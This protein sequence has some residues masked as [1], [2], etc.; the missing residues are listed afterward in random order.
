MTFNK[1]NRRL[2]VA[3]IVFISS[4][5]IVNSQTLFPRDNEHA[6]PVTAPAA[7][8]LY[9]P[10]EILNGP[11]PR[12]FF[13]E[14]PVAVIQKRIANPAYANTWK[15]I[16]EKA[17][18][19]AAAIPTDTIDVNDESLRKEAD[20]F[21]WMALAYTLDTNKKNRSIYMKGL[22]KWINAWYGYKLSTQDLVS[23][24][25]I[26]GMS[27]AYD[28]MYADFKAPVRD[29]LR[30]LIVNY[31][32]WLRS[33]KNFG[34]SMW[35]NKHYGANHNWYNNA[36]L[37][38]A[39]FALWGEKG[40]NDAD[41]PALWLNSAMRYFWEFQRRLSSEAVPIE[42]FNYADYGIKP[43]LDFAVVAEQLTNLSKLMP[44]IDCGA[45]KNSPEARLSVMLP[46]EL[47]FL[48]WSDSNWKHF[49]DSWQFR[50]CA[51][52]FNDGYAQNL[53]SIMEK[54]SNIYNWRNIFYYDP[55]IPEKAIESLPLTADFEDL[56]MY[57]ARNSWKG[58]Q[59]LF[60]FKCGLA[61]G[62]EG[63]AIERDFCTGHCQP[64][65]NT[66]TF[67]WNEHPIIDRPGYERIKKASHH[68]L[69]R[70]VYK[71]NEVEQAGGG[72]QWFMLFP[73][74]CLSG[75]QDRMGDASTLEVKHTADYHAYLGESGGLYVLNYNPC[76]YRRRVV[77]FPTGAV[78]IADRITTP[79]NTD[80]T[81]RL[82]TLRNDLK[83]EGN[84]F[85]F[86]A[87]ETKGTI[88]DYSEG[89][90]SREI[91]HEKVYAW[92][93]SD[94]DGFPIDRQVVNVTKKNTRE[95]YF[96]SVINMADNKIKIK[97]ITEQGIVVI[98]N[99]GDEIFFGWG[100]N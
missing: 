93:H 44:L 33:P 81:F 12:L 82:L 80:I 2:A 7:Q 57:V 87:G 94:T 66:V 72:R 36:A 28:W 84:V 60:N 9:T 4:C 95:A 18:S 77:Y 16:K 53:A 13:G 50:F 83:Q 54:K 89:V 3:G 55:S 64:D 42:G 30:F 23:S 20:Y 19:S 71:G 14:T 25:L 17:L 56:E 78:V 10:K 70:I 69:S 98:G 100:E 24:Q 45:I 62:K 35:R 74:D 34:A 27:N 75:Y 76:G 38:I 32:R 46:N 43:Y 88:T 51:S 65:A 15:M 49:A 31:S 52:R 99:N 58:N 61:G 67:W 22:E 8:L 1:T 6:G 92:D 21:T 39:A 79:E 48:C 86:T 68:Q 59:N 37:G 47:G 85:S 96:G 91:T 63:A 73:G 97:K 5:F 26:L 40:L 11:H 29:K 41:E 90:D